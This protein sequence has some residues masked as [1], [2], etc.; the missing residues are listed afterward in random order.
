MSNTQ[1]TPGP[2]YADKNGGIWRR[3]PS[4]LYENGGGVA[5][6]RQLA[7]VWKGWVNE[8]QIGYPLEANARLI[9]AAPDLLESIQEVITANAS[10]GKA[11]G[12]FSLQR[13][14]KDHQRRVLLAWQ[15][16]H[17]AIAKATG[18]K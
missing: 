8:G 7:T 10:E 13:P 4:D 12:G 3:H 14:T 15:K 17:A 11:P 5:G 18:E 16:V 6:D 2:W 9:A 1:H